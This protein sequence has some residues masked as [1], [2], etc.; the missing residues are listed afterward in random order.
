MINIIHYVL[1]VTIFL[2]SSFQVYADN[3][4]PGRQS[5]KPMEIT[6]DSMEVFKDK[7]LVVFSGKAKVMQGNS[8][9]KSDKLFLYYKTES[10]NKSKIGIIKTD[11]IG[12][13]ER[14]EAKGNVYLN[15]EDRIA[16]GD[17][18]IYYRDSN[19]VI[20]IGNATLKDGKN[21]IKGDRVIVFLNENRG[22]VE[23]NTQKQAKAIIYPNDIKKIGTKQDRSLT[24]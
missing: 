11:K 6:S 2:L 16:T 23:G 20:M 1:V 3:N 8:V 4:F 19:K 18:A 12:E 7:K 13:L 21:F 22:I 15:Q 14:I 5:D 9:L 24:P 17:E 10:D